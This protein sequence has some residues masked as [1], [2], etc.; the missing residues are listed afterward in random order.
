MNFLDFL[1]DRSDDMLEL[2]LEH[3]AVVAV[4]VGLASLIGIGLGIAT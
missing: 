1:V 2:G 4:S 3:A